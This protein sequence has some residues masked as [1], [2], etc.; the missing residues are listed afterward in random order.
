[1]LGIAQCIWIFVAYWV[2]NL[3]AE[4]S[5]LFVTY[6]DDGTHNAATIRNYHSSVRTVA[7][8]MGINV[9]KHEFPDVLLVLKGI[10]RGRKIAPKLAHPMTLSI[11]LKIR[12]NLDLDNPVHATMWS[13]FLTSFFLMLCKSNVCHT[14][15]TARNYLERKCEC[16]M[17]L[18]ISAYFLDKDPPVG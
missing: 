9:T 15:G 1:M 18:C 16:K 14:Y 4:K 11:L 12:D 7:W 2:L 5:V 6:L 10:Q 8:L 13:L 3:E 17:K